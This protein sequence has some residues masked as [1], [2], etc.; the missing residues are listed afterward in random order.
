MKKATFFQRLVAYLIDMILL[1]LIL[2]IVTT[3]IDTTKMDDINN[4]M[5]DVS[6]S[7]IEGEMSPTEYLEKTNDLTYD[8]NK[9]SIL[10]NGISLALVVAY[11]TVFQYLNKGQT[12]GKKL[13]K[14]KVSQKD[15]DNPS[16]GAMVIRT[17]I[18]DGIISSFLSVVLIFVLNKSTYSTVYTVYSL[19]FELIV[20]ISA[21]MILY[22]KDKK[23]V[24]DMIAKTEVICEGGK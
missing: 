23:G 7:Y 21:F 12:I 2:V 15:K 8:L 19:V 4:Q 16:V 5:M 3:G 14:I 1:N 18:I 24:H 17:F 13:L 9:A 6:S 11:F 22:R 20:I 10:V